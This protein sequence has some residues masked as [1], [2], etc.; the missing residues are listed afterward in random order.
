MLV[1]KR[2]RCLELLHN[3]FCR[4][5]RFLPDQH[6]LDELFVL[7]GVEYSCDCFQRPLDVAVVIALWSEFCKLL[8]FALRYIS[9]LV[10]VEEGLIFRAKFSLALSKETLQLLEVV[11]QPLPHASAVEHRLDRVVLVK[12]AVLLLNCFRCSLSFVNY[13]PR[14]RLT[15]CTIWVWHRLLLSFRLDLLYLIPLNLNYSTSSWLLRL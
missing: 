10:Y 15:E 8:R 14:L 4:M 1:S 6:C 7:E 2:Q 13:V 5:L 12:F 9:V 3:S 11:N